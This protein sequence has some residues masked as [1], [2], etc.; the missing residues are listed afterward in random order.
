MFFCFFLLFFPPFFCFFDYNA[1]SRGVFSPDLGARTWQFVMLTCAFNPAEIDQYSPNVTVEFNETAYNNEDLQRK[2]IEEELLTKTAKK[3]TLLVIDSASFHKSDNI[4]TLL[5]NNN[6][7]PAVIPGGLTPIVQPL[8]THINVAL[9]KFLFEEADLYI[10]EINHGNGDI[11]GWDPSKKRIMITH[12]VDRAVRRL[13]Q[14]DGLIVKSFV[15]TGI[16]IAPNGSEDHLIRIKGHKSSDFDFSGWQN[17]SNNEDRLP[18]PHVLDVEENE[19]IDTLLTS[20]NHIP[21]NRLRR[22]ASIRKIQGRSAMDRLALL[23]ALRGEDYKTG[24]PRQVDGVALD[25]EGPIKREGPDSTAYF[26]GFGD[27]KGSP[28]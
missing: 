18:K 9:K 22:W 20:G 15:D 14:I 12:I 19:V 7:I 10:D 23:A 5:E 11:E 8:D 17:A 1:G 13:E 4:L 27:F 16:S 2:W 28:E 6:V 3:P 25:Y 26:Q 21:L 24:L